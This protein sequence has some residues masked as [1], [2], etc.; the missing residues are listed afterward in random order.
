MDERLLEQLKNMP[1]EFLDDFGELERRINFYADLDK[2][3]KE[4]QERLNY[5]LGL[6]KKFGLAKHF[7]FGFELH[8][9]DSF[10]ISLE[11]EN[12]SY[13]NYLLGISTVNP[14]KYNLP[15]ERYF[16]EYRNFLSGYYV[17]VEKGRKGLLL[18]H[19]YQRFG[20]STILRANEDE[21]IYYVSAKPFDSR[22]IKESVIVAKLNEE[23]YEENIS[24]LTSSEL[25][26]LGF[27]SF[28]VEEGNKISHFDKEKYLEQEIYE[29]A[30]ELFL[31]NR[32]E[33]E[34][35]TEIEEVK[36][37]LKYTEYKLIYQEQLMEILHKLCGYDMSKA[38]FYRR[39]IVKRKRDSLKELGKMLTDKYGEKGKSLF[40]YLLKNS[41]YAVQKAYVIANLYS[42]IEY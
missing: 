19:L 37:V 34:S 14:V 8:L 1:C 26:K 22:L 39:E 21:R 15:F 28:W 3:S 36:E 2:I 18:K 24:L 20:K 33:V 31:D 23:A 27:Y 42:L 29:K 25:T 17:Y 35:F 32:P 38:D 40:D 10:G 5:E 9:N 11:I 30:K 13:V 16:N 7:L 4:E 41:L 12:Y 6:I